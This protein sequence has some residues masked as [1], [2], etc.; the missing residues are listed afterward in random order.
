LEL[1]EVLTGY[2][3]IGW[4]SDGEKWAQFVASANDQS[5]RLHY[6]LYYTRRTAGRQHL[7]SCFT[8]TVWNHQNQPGLY[9]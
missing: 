2:M 4:L 7:T 9:I 5:A 8:T 6:R 1:S 3:T